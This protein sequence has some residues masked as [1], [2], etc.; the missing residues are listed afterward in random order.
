MDIGTTGRIR[1]KAM[2]MITQSIPFT[3]CLSNH[4]VVIGCDRAGGYLVVIGC[5]R[6]GGYLVVIGSVWLYLECVLTAA[7]DF[8]CVL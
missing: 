7:T 2:D 8:V 3:S 6:A 1:L 4:L 5:D